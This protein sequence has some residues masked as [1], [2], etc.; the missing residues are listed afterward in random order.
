MKDGVLLLGATG[1]VGES[2]L[3][4]LR[5]LQ[6]PLL[7]FSFCNNL[8]IAK[9]IILE[10][11]PL[12]VLCF[13]AEYESDIKRIS[14]KITVFKNLDGL[15]EILDFKE[16]FSVINAMGGM[17]GLFPSYY[18]LLSKRKL[19]LA[20]KES[21]VAGSKLLLKERQYK[22]QLIPIDSEHWSLFLLSQNIKK[23]S[24]KN[25]IL[26][27]SGGPFWKT[28]VNKLLDVDKKAVLKHPVWSMGASISVGSALMSNKG[29]EVLEAKELFN[30]PE[31]R[32]KVFIHPQAKVHGMLRLKDGSLITHVS[33]TDM[34]E[35]IKNALLYPDMPVGEDFSFTNQKG[36]DFFSVDFNRFPLLKLAYEASKKGHFYQIVYTVANEAAIELFLKDKLS[37]YNLPKVVERVFNEIPKEAVLDLDTVLKISDKVRN[38]T[39]AIVLNK[40]ES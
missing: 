31:N 10:F 15:Q 8:E 23:S 35:P 3:R 39:N 22:N 17:A 40:G 32:I 14:S 11:N 34:I 27:A 16:S 2:S 1:S 6:I 38:W 9:K 33:E 30:V 26:T 13:N 28:P 5:A 37:F 12:W 4:A 29:L 20:N 36:F 24:I 25:F 21:I 19:I 18:T 7:G